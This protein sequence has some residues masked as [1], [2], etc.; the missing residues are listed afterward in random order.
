[1][2]HMVVGQPTRAAFNR[3]ASDSG[4]GVQYNEC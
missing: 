2:G 3:P 4:T 1:M